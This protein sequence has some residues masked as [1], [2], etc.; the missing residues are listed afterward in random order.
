VKPYKPNFGP[1]W[2]LWMVLG[3]VFFF[4]VAYGSGF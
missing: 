3:M 1:W 4:A 2:L